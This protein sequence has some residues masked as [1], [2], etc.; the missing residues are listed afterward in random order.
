MIYLFCCHFCLWLPFCSIKSVYRCSVMACMHGEPNK[1]HPKSTPIHKQIR[2]V[3]TV[4]RRRPHAQHKSYKLA[5]NKLQLPT[6]TPASNPASF[7]FSIKHHGEGGKTCPKP[8]QL[9]LRTAKFCKAVS[10]VFESLQQVWALC[11]T[12]WL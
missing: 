1:D 3:C 4:H 12:I 2:S 7:R 11:L 5:N 6:T 9:P 8:C 10:P